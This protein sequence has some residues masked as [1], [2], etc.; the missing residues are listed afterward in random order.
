MTTKH[1]DLAERLHTD[2][3][4]G[5]FG[6][7]ADEEDLDQ[8]AL[9]RLG[10]WAVSAI[11]ALVLAILVSQ[12][13]GQNQQG[14]VVSADLARQAQQI[15]RI[16]KEAQAELTRLG[17]AIDTLNGD[18]DRLFTR[19]TVLEQNLDSVTGSIVRQA[20]AFPSPLPAPTAAPSPPASAH[21]P[22]PHSAAAPAARDSEKAGPAP[23]AAEPPPT[24][25]IAE[26][27]P[28]AKTSADTPAAPTKPEVVIS[29]SMLGPPDPAAGRLIDTAAPAPPTLQDSDPHLSA[30]AS[31]VSAPR[32][33][34]PPA[35]VSTTQEIEVTPAPPKLPAVAVPRTDFG[36]DLGGA[37]SLDNLRVMWSRL[38]KT[39]KTLSALTPVVT[40]R[41]RN[42]GTQLRL[43]AGPINDA[44]TAAKLCAGLTAA[45]QY[46]EM[47]KYDGQRLSTKPAA[48]APAPPPQKKRTNARFTPAEPEPEPAPPPP[49]APPAHSSH[50]PH[51]SLTSLL[52]MR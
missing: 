6:V 26:P 40:V 52:G 13:S 50:S 22:K 16:T 39:H 34:A 43:I 5:L 25:T 8:R 11:G 20:A 44:A 30:R 12:S 29:R 28:A 19:V 14:Q 49:P 18:R 9:W 47:S 37:T 24:E 51:P 42:A 1:A 15:Q 3:D 4:R 23:A 33:L 10:S 45:D 21:A 41:E 48:P 17:T 35:I 38:I 32:S 31:L 2:P 27:A 46:C 36:I 7:F